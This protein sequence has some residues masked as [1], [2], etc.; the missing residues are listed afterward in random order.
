MSC[1]ILGD[2]KALTPSQRL[3]YAQASSI[4][5]RVQAYNN[6]IRGKRLAGNTQVSYYVF[7][8]NTEKTM[9]KLGQYLFTQNDPTNAALYASVKE[10]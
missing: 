5:T 6:N 2:M 9:F 1:L 10:I 4:F 8:D 7:A 3:Q